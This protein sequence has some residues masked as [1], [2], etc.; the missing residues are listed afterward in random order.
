[1]EKNSTVLCYSLNYYS[2]KISSA[3]FVFELRDVKF[4]YLHFEQYVRFMQNTLAY[5][6]WIS[7]TGERSAEGDMF[8]WAMSIGK[9]PIDML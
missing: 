1:V 3:L 6:D 2:L 5:S 4:G 8:G 9:M 7:D